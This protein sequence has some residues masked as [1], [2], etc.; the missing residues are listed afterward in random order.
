MSR[1]VLRQPKISNHEP[2]GDTR[3]TTIPPPGW[4]DLRTGVIASLNCSGTACQVFGLFEPAPVPHSL[5]STRKPHREHSDDDQRIL[6][7]HHKMS[8]SSSLNTTI[9]QLLASGTILES[10][11]NSVGGFPAGRFTPYANL[12]AEQVR[13]ASILGYSSSNTNQWDRPGQRKQEL[14]SWRKQC[15]RDPI[16]RK[17][18]ELCYKKEL[19]QDVLGFETEEIWDCWSTHYL[20]FNWDE[21]V[22]SGKVVSFQAMGWTQKVNPMF[23]SAFLGIYVRWFAVMNMHL[24]FFTKLRRSSA[25]LGQ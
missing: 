12:T 11:I 13:A 25:E 21:L 19:L 18:P 24:K 23:K 4:S 10:L 16:T 6:H 20:H 9:D 5:R 15:D 3:K 22:E 14:K 8:L 7:H 17:R 2:G 1:L